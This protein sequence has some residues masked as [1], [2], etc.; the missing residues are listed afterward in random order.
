MARASLAFAGAV[1]EIAYIVD[2]SLVI[3]LELESGTEG[4]LSLNSVIRF[5]KKQVSDPVTRRVII[6][7]IVMWFAKE[8]GSALLGRSG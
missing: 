6:I 5:V 8:T 3:R 4:S 7:G 1:R 2:P